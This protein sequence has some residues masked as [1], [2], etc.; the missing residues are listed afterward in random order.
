MN[1]TASHKATQH[2]AQEQVNKRLERSEDTNRRITE[3]II[4]NGKLYSQDYFSIKS[5]LEATRTLF[6]DDKV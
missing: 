2:G 6:V 4:K 3:P 1:I 5:N